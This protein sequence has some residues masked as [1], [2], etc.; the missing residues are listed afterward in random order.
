MANENMTLMEENINFNELEEVQDKLEKEISDL[1][2]LEKEK[3]GNPE[4]LG[5]AIKDVIWE[6]FI[7][8]IAITAGEDFIKENNGLTLDLSDEAHIQTAE[9]FEKGKIAEHNYISKEQ[10]EQNYHRY[11]NTPH[12]EFRK[13]YVN[14]EMDANLE[15]I[16]KLN[17]KGIDTVTDIYTGRQIP[18]KKKLENGKDNPK[19]AQREHVKSSSEVYKNS[20]LQMANN[21]KEL[22]DIINSPENLQ[23]YTTAERNGRKSDN[24]ADKMNKKD[25]TKHWEKADKKAEK[26]I[27]QKEEEGKERLKKEGLK[28]Q[29]EEAFR[30]GGKALRVAIMSLI[31]ELA[32][33][34]V[35]K[36]IKW[37]KLEKK[38]LSTLKKS[39]KEAINS[40]ISKI[41]QHLIN[42]GNTISTTIMTAIIGP[43]F[44]TLKKIWMVLKKAGKSVKEAI[45]YIKN[46]ENREKSL[47]VLML[48]VSKIILAGLTGISAIVL[49]EVIE[50]GLMGIPIFA[51]EIPLIGSL[52][53]ILGIFLGAVVSGITGAI[54][55]N[56]ITK[57]VSKK[58]DSEIT[59]KQIDKGNKI[60]SLQ[61]E[62]FNLKKEE[63][64]TQK[65]KKG[66]EIKRRHEEAD[67]YIKQ[68][69]NKFSEE[70]N[71]I[72][73]ANFNEINYSDNQ[74]DFN[75]IDKMLE[76]FKF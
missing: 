2:F 35:K 71:S 19:A 31:A 67:E 49:S 27:K 18:T 5:N 74:D 56:F 59:K 60:L 38:E 24:S 13:K 76:D 12:K 16:G 22:A 9:N 23:G 75:E 33:E 65:E 36:L 29:K 3:I 8:Q 39:F 20:S 14:P 68:I 72:K 73:E 46:P 17:E 34:I 15:R 7:N 47:S 53:N 32:K 42:A 70:K 61:E 55:I 64:E 6:Q 44:A 69:L 52:A 10:L 28:T 66:M 26:H 62:V 21:N 54:I 1:D 51:I 43:I 41:K 40:F 30:I 4:N 11:K 48:E 45:F 25:K 58:H 50:K 63:L 37:F 57:I